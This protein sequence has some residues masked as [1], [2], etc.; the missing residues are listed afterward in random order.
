MNNVP[1]TRCYESQ[2]KIR[3]REKKN[4]GFVRY[5]PCVVVGFLD[6][7]MITLFMMRDFNTSASAAMFN[8]GYGIFK[9]IFDPKICGFIY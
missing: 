3:E 8:C 2:Q 7:N 9:S 4:V 6:E 1:T 5:G